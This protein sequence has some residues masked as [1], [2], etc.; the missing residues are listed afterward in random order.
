[1]VEVFQLY[2]IS[3]QITQHVMMLWIYITKCRYCTFCTWTKI[4][5]W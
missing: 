4:R 1:M 3:L 5:I 2:I